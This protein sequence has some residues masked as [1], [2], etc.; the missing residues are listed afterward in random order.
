MIGNAV[1]QVFLLP[2]TLV[3][4]ALGARGR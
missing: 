1:F 2:D 3:C 4:N